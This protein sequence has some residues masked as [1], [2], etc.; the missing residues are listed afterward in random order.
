MIS[1]LWSMLVVCSSNLH[2]M[3]QCVR[4]WDYIPAYYQDYVEFK[5][6]TVYYRERQALEK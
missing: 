6:H 3:G 1:I 5:T 4:V 2:N